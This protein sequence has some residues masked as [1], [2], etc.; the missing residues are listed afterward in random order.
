[1]CWGVDGEGARRDEH[2][3]LFFGVQARLAA[4]AAVIFC[5][6]SRD[7]NPA[8]QMRGSDSVGC[9]PVPPAAVVLQLDVTPCCRDRCRLRHLKLKESGQ[10]PLRRCRAVAVVQQIVLGFFLAGFW[11]GPMSCC[12][13]CPVQEHIF[14]QSVVITNL[15]GCGFQGVEHPS[16]IPRDSHIQAALLGQ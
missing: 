11:I 7:S 9:N 15:S 6:T 13:R 2:V 3:A 5:V 4:R 12:Q 8:W 14:A 16:E 1:M 10:S